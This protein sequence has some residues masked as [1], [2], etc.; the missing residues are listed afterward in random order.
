MRLYKKININSAHKLN[1]PY[2]SKCNNLHGHNYLIEIWINGEPDNL[3]IIINFS[4]IKDLVKQLDHKYLNDFIEVPTCEN[5]VIYLLKQI[6]GIVTSNI[7]NIKVRVWE[8]E[9]SYIEKEKN[10]KVN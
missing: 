9:N 10:I 6:E 3:G 1:L 7:T 4:V 5:L 2:K 8:T